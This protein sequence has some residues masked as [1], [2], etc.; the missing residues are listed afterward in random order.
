M[1]RI[2]NSDLDVFPLCLGGNVFGWTADE[3]AS[4]AVLDA[5][6][7]G[8]RQLH[9][10]RRLLLDLGARARRRRVGDDH[11]PLDDGARQPRRSRRRDQGRP[12][13]ARGLGA[14][15]VASAAEDSLRR[16]Q[17]DYIDLYYA[18]NDDPDTP[19]EE[20]LGAL[21]R[22]GR[23][24]GKVRPL[25]ASNSRPTA[26]PQALER[27][28]ARGLAALRRA[29]AAYNLVERGDYEGELAGRC[30]S[31]DGLACV[32]YYG[33]ARGFLTG[34]YRPARRWTARGRRA[35]GGTC[36]ERGCAVLAA[37]DEIAAAHDAGRRRRA[38]LAAA[39]PTV[40]APIASART[41]E[42][43]PELLAMAVLDLTARELAA[44][45]AASA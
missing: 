5:Y 7:A 6:A 28:R 13:P 14:D 24:T 11:R 10:H 8:G 3:D 25:A 40:V 29:A 37:L 12:A 35:A 23:A 20:T 44:L 39:Q 4:F 33:L 45:D 26:S 43:L 18:H 19:L 15:S 17:T 1:S 22:A 16:L 34:K 27:R 21:R 41:V 38:G 36:D 2:G 31:R 32:P 9:R 42:Q 30:A